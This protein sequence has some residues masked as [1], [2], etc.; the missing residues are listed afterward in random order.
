[1]DRNPYAKAELA[2]ELPFWIYNKPAYYNTIGAQDGKQGV[3]RMILPSHD[4][5]YQAD[6]DEGYDAGLYMRQFLL[7]TSM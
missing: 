5:D 2:D 7:A 3:E 4:V 1:M 6:Y